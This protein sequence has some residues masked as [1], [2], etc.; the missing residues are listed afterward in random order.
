LQ[1]SDARNLT[2]V[3]IAGVARK[4]LRWA[5]PATFGADL[6]FGET[7]EWLVGP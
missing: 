7:S 2:A 6:A 5:A 3:S 1:T 4:R